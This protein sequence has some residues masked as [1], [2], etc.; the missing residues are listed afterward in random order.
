MVSAG[1]QMQD[2]SKQAVERI[3]SKLVTTEAIANAANLELRSQNEKLMKLDE[4]LNEIEGLS[5]RTDKYVR[6]LGR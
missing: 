3:Q 5:K 4:K 2:K 6:T 1:D